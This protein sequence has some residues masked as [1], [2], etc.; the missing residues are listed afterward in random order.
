[1]SEGA[2][3]R[4]D[5]VIPGFDHGVR[6]HGYIGVRKQYLPSSR[7]SYYGYDFLLHAFGR[8]IICMYLDLLTAQGI[9]DR[10]I[11]SSKLNTCM[12][13]VHASLLCYKDYSVKNNNNSNIIF[14]L[15][16]S[17]FLSVLYFVHDSIINK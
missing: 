9:K 15:S 3:R 13:T 7:H 17:V 8:R 14:S 10:P 6:R 11:V 4:R 5:M 1:M 16:V 2:P 12:L